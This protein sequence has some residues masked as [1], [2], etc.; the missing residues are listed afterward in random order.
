MAPAFCKAFAKLFGISTTPFVKLLRKSIPQEVDPY[1]SAQDG[2]QSTQG[3]ELSA[4]GDSPLSKFSSILR[5]FKE[6]RLLVA[7]IPKDA[8]LIDVA[9]INAEAALAKFKQYVDWVKENPRQATLIAACI[10]IPIAFTVALIAVCI[11]ILVAFTAALIAACIIIPI[12]FPVAT[13]L[14][15]IGFSVAVPVAGM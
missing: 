12:V 10:V 4:R 13:P 7:E 6:G 5:R 9:R 1:P 3:G 15:A 14:G 8:S 11:I 2:N